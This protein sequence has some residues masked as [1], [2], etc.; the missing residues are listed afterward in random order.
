M[1]QRGSLLLLVMMV[2]VAAMADTTN[3]ADGFRIVISTW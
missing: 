2:V 1:A 3:G